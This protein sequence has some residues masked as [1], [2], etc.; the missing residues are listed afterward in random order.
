MLH[1]LAAVIYIYLAFYMYYLD[2]K[3]QLNRTAV[4]L[5]ACFALWSTGMTVLSNTA[6]PEAVMLVFWR[7]YPLGWISFPPIAWLLY[8]YMSK[9]DFFQRKKLL[10][11]PIAAPVLFFYI[12]HCNNLLM[13]VP[14]LGHYGWFPVWKNNVWSFL[15]YIYYIS[16]IIAGLIVISRFALKTRN[17]ALKKSCFIIILGTVITLFAGTFL[18]IV[19][20]RVEKDPSLF[21][22]S[23]DIIILIWSFFMMYSVRKYSFFKITPASAADKIIASMNESLTLVNEYF[24]IEFINDDALRLLGYNREELIGRPYTSLF[25][26]RYESNLW[27][28]N[29]LKKE[30]SKGFETVF[31]SKKGEHI[32]VLLSASL[33]KEANIITGAVCVASDIRAMKKAAEELTILHTAVE[34]SPSSLIITDIH[35]TITY[36]NPKFCSVTGY[37]KDEALGQNPRILKSGELSRDIYAELWNT[38]LSGNEWHGIFHNRRKD[39]ELFWESASISPIRDDNGRIS[40]FVAVKEDITDLIQAENELKQSYTKLKEL[41]SLK[42]SFMSMISHELRTPITS[43]NGF[44]SFL[45]S[46]VGG[47]ISEQQKDFLESIRSNSDRL[48]RL[49]NDLLDTA[50]MESGSFSI[51]KRRSDLKVIISNCTKDIKSLIS[52]KRIGLFINV[53]D[54]AVFADVDDYRISQSLINLLNNA[55]KFSPFE[56]TITITLKQV[57][58]A[59]DV[60]P[61]YAVSSGLKTGPYIYLSVNDQGMGIETDKLQKI[62]ERFYQVENIN[63]R[64][65]QGTGLGLN[66]V[67]NIV[68]LH[69]GIVWAESDGKGKGSTFII[70]I[71]E[72]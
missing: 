31:I 9:E 21:S 5:F 12:L 29:V 51:S 71:P 33:I 69:N 25:F 43:I 6:T 20:S 27:I 19:F 47:Q 56:S 50:K 15:F 34:Q 60:I 39:G 54:E 28:K 58:N 48:L 24:E 38:I 8:I 22:M 4:V 30:S 16:F 37:S 13:N 45:L 63:T 40:S 36:V 42:A 7:I 64:T 46:G 2:K 14:V 3:S 23:T 49:I 57:T 59:S 66:I 70:L 53:P 26:S 44:L 72:R 65:V 18:E 10:L 62:F 61:A 55:I 11:F 52:K 68:T 1:L 17:K 67:S 35:G 32:D 41:D